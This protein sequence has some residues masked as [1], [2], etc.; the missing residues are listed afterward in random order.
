MPTTF[1]QKTG[2]DPSGW[3]I[4]VTENTNNNLISYS[5]TPPQ[6][7]QVNLMAW[8]T[9][10]GLSMSKLGAQIG[11]TAQGAHSM[12][13]S[14]TVHPY[15]HAQLLAL[16]IPAELLP[17]AELTKPGPK[18]AALRKRKPGEAEASACLATEKTEEK[19]GANEQ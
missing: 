18:G 12:I 9:E 14:E 5:I 6:Y 19:E 8:L 17:A 16:G 4:K 1:A 7:R 11:V 13:K 3:T 15:R 10:R 2:S